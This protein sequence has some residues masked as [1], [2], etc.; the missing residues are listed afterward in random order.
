MFQKLVAIEPISLIP[1]AEK[2][3]QAEK[4]GLVNKVENCSGSSYV[5][6]IGAYHIIDGDLILGFFPK[7]K[8]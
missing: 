3:F 5:K 4:A 8:K 7:R 1:S 2:E 6:Y